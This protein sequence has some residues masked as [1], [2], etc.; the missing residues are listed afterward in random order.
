MFTRLALSTYLVLFA[1][2]FRSEARA[3]TT[4]T[5]HLTL[6]DAE[7]QLLQKNI[8]L[9]VQKYSIDSA[10]AG[11]ITARLYDNPQVTF[12]N[13][14]YSH[15]EKK[16]FDLGYTG[17]NTL[18][19]QQLIKLA[20]KRNKAVKLAQSGVKLSEYEFYDLLRTLRFSLRDNFYDLYYKQQSLSTY[21]NQ[22]A[23]LQKVVKAFTE[24]KESGNIAP[25]EVIRIKS[26]LYDL[27]HDQ[28][29]LQEDIRQTVS[30]LALLIR[31]PATVY[32]VPELPAQ[33]GK[34]PVLQYSYEA[35]LDT[36]RHNR[37]DLKIAR[38]SVNYSQ[39]NLR[40]QKAMA[41]PD[42]QVGFAY[43]KQ[44]NFERNYNGLNI[45]MPLPFFNR[46]QGNI[47]TAKALAESSKA[48]LQG[49][50][51]QLSHEVALSLE[52]ALRTEKLLEDFDPDFGNDYTK[53]MTEVEKNFKSRNLGLLE[54]LDLYDAYR[55]NVLKMNELK[56]NRLHAL[57]NINYSTGSQLF[58]P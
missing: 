32:I 47:K 9:L 3:Q 4:D 38:E 13:V 54:F 45:S 46:N 37:Y 10:K 29:Q 7:Q 5:L 27:Q 1:V 33:T 51:D 34:P 41:V 21:Q 49:Q 14:L 40:L 25:K 53:M 36:A 58:H 6:P 26:L 28:L 57:E 43:D 2:L 48:Q 15:T 22:V 56:Y 44:G 19:V 35:L 18:Q 20:G 11:I 42:L 23:F 12:E 52:S 50:E 17:Q 30:D 16:W 55:S 8:P 24:Q 39:L 31:I